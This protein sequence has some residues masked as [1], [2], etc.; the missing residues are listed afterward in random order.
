MTR[1]IVGISTAP[2]GLPERTLGWDAL[3]W[4]AEYLQQPDGPDADDPWKFTSEQARWVLWWYAV[5]DDGRFSYRYSMLRRMK[6]WGKDPHAAAVCCIEFVGPC[7]FAGWKKDGTPMSMPHA[8]SWVQTAAV[9]REQTKNMMTLFPG[10]LSKR[11]I[12]EY[13]IDI[14]KQ[15]IYAHQGRCRIEAVTSSPKALEG[16]RATF[17]VKDE[18]HH[19]LHNNEGIAMAD[20]IARNAAKSRD[21]SSRVLAI[22]NA[23][24]PGQGSDAERDYEAFQQGAP[25]MLYDSLEAP[26]VEDLN[27]TDSLRPALSYARGDSWWL[28]E[29]RL[30]AEIQDP[31]SPS[32]T[33]RRYYLN[34]LAAADDRA[35]DMDQWV[36]LAARKTMVNGAMITLGF[37]GS[38][39]RDHTALIATEVGR[40]ILA[41]CA[42]D[43]GGVPDPRSRD[44]RGRVGDVREVQRAA[45]LRGPAVL[46]REDCNVVGS[47]QPP[48]PG[49]GD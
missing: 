15:I 19:W 10:M 2:A 42:D 46:A 4:S 22:S 5:N 20:V 34:Q 30:V 13:G 40:R 38:E 47:V 39:T 27:D 35:F 21:G 9:A 1:R 17:N 16:G 6:G 28:D 25:D 45:L 43:G 8:A 12:E 29:D 49:E 23:H 32:N 18:T 44:R 7:R 11:A 24:A 14:G 3:G 48:Q 36:S 31:R 33:S 26:V 37:D 41:P